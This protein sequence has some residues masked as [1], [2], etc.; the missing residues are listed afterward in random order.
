MLS[1]EKAK[2]TNMYNVKLL[3]KIS[4]MENIRLSKKD[5]LIGEAV[6]RPDAI[7]VSSAV[8]TDMEFNPELL[9]IASTGIGVGNI[10]VE[11][12]TKAGIAVF[13]TPGSDANGVKELT[14]CALLL[15]S[16][17]ITDGIE[18]ER[19]LAGNPN[20]VKLIEKKHTEFA[21]SE[22]DGK[23][24]GVIGLGAIGGLVANSAVD[25]GMKVIGCDP[26]L[27]VEAA[28][29]LSGNVEK[30]TYHDIFKASD[31]ITLHIP[32]TKETAKLINADAIAEM[33]DGVKI[34]NLSNA[35]VVD[36]RAI[37]DALASGKIASYVTDFA[38]PELIGLKGVIA[39]PHLGSLTVESDENCAAMAAAQIDSYIK[40]GNIKNSVNF[41]DV[42]V[43][44]LSRTRVCIFH[45]NIPNMIAQI[46]S[47]FS[48]EK[49]NLE[50]L[51]GMA[52]NDSA[53]SILDLNAEVPMNVVN[54]LNSIKG[55]NRVRIIN[56]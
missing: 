13:N 52:R 22:L 49:L 46:S 9:C 10:P 53:Y 48:E 31:Y 47:A 41:P 8:M 6:K 33:K 36:A 42:S 25:L 23:T 38:T 45:D 51:F 28:W 12:C 34:V 7:M 50:N 14:L 43:P 32:S 56:R 37:A 19:S 2:V 4:G 44:F 54:R 15:A 21:G 30:A 35:D 55:V 17:R 24:L 29:R 39:M 26:Y 16:R 5:Y 20:A 40:C 11:R 27:S 18:W 1:H 3:N